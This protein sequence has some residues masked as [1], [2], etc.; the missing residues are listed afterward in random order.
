[1]S[2]IRILVLEDDAELRETL[3]AV[4]T[5]EGYLVVSAANGEAAVAAAMVIGQNVG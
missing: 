1:M 5:C 3:E 4:L 2:D